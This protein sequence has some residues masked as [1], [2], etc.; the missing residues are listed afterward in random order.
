MYSWCIDLKTSCRRLDDSLRRPIFRTWDQKQRRSTTLPMIRQRHV[1]GKETLWWPLVIRPRINL[2]SVYTTHWSCN[3]K[4][5]LARRS[6][7]EIVKDVGACTWM[8]QPTLYEATSICVQAPGR[9]HEC[10]SFFRLYNMLGMYGSFQVRLAVY[11]LQ[12]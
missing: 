6:P 7:H 1:C 5:E 4:Y 10:S 2:R 9:R 12:A 8:Y 3:M 11:E